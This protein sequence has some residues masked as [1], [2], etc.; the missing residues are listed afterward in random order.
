MLLPARGKTRIIRFA[1]VAFVLAFCHPAAER[2]TATI[3]LLRHQSSRSGIRKEAR[4]P[5]RGNTH[6]TSRQ[7][8]SATASGVCPASISFTRSGSRRARS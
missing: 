4:H 1:P 5:N 6:S 7:I 3:T 2:A 8:Q